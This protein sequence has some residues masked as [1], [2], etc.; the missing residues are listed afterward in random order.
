MKTVG[1]AISF[2]TSFWLLLQKE[3]RRT[4]SVF[5]FMAFS[6]QVASVSRL[7]PTTAASLASCSFRNDFVDNTIFLS[8][9]R[10]HDVVAFHV[11]FNAF[12]RLLDVRRQDFIEN[13]SDAQ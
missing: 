3:H 9:L 1:P 8:L 10:R 11:F 7:K 6:F 5:F 12:E 2:R 4:S 13:R